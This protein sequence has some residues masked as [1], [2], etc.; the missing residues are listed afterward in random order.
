MRKKIL[1][2]R[3]RLAQRY[4]NFIIRRLETTIELT[5]NTED[6]D[7]DMLFNFWLSQGYSL[8]EK[9]INKYEIYLD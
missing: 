7:G 9:M 6:Y 3:R 2:Y 4:A 1:E 5:K 8:N